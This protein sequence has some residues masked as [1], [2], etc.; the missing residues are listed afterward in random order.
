[1]S[2]SADV[3]VKITGDCPVIDPLI[4]E[5]AIQMFLHNECDYLTNAH[6]RS[7]PDGMDT[8]VFYLDTLKK[9][10]AMTTDR[11]DH[12]HVTLHI[13]HHPEVFRTIHLVAPRDQC[14]PELGLTLDERKDYVLLTKLIEH[15]GISRHL[16]SCREAVAEL[17]RH[18]D[19]LEINKDVRRKGDT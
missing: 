6:I 16:F 19:W 12:E 14:W 1:V 9:S 15:F 17:R 4:V 2:A 3:V 8:E 10:A 11:L 13:R 5:Q 18:P 7:Y